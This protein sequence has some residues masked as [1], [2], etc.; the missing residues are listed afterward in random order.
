MGCYA[1][2]TEPLP[3]GSKSSAHT[4]SLVVEDERR[5]VELARLIAGDST[6]EIVVDVPKPVD[7]DVG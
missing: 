4:V 2:N 7:K 3:P 1:D 6:P 5:A